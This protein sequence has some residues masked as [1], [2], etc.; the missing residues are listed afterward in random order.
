MQAQEKALL[1][2]PAEE[3]GGDARDSRDSRETGRASPNKART[4]TGH[5]T[6][7]GA[8]PATAVGVLPRAAWTPSSQR[9][10]SVCGV[11][12]GDNQGINRWFLTFTPMQAPPESGGIW[13]GFTSDLPLGRLQGGSSL[14]MY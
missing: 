1:K 8:R 6:A 7:I 3:G 13:G 9:H 10:A 11:H 14:T 5:T 2:Q 4:A 12:P